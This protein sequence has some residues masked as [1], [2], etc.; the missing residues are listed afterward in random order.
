MR[1]KL[2]FCW[3]YG[4]LLYIPF[5]DIICI[6]LLNAYHSIEGLKVKCI[7][8]DSESEGLLIVCL[9]V[10]LFISSLCFC[11]CLIVFALGWKEM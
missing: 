2:A 1:E 5:L 8:V 10:C 3:T 6:F 11:M 4:D 7:G 9:L